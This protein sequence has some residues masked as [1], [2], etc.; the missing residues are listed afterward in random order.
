[1]R[2]TIGPSSG[3]VVWWICRASVVVG[4]SSGFALWAVVDWDIT[5]KGDR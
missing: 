1:M 5:L 2:A 4:R 3:G